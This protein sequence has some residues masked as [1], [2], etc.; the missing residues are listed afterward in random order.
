MEMGSCDGGRRTWV[1]VPASPQSAGRGRPAGPRCGRCSLNTATQR[2]SC[3]SQGWVHP[4]QRTSRRR[5]TGMT[6]GGFEKQSRWSWGTTNP[7]GWAG[8]TRKPP[9]AEPSGRC[10]LWRPWVPG[11]PEWMHITKRCCIRTW[12]PC[13][14]MNLMGQDDQAQSG[15]RDGPGCG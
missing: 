6:A 5:C 4:R 1:A 12:S 11:C 15:H 10:H 2:G 9:R 13:V 8:E 7:W 3:P 14:K